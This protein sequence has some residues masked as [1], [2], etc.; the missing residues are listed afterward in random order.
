MVVQGCGPIG[1]MMIACLPT[2]GVN[3]IIALDGNDSRL[4]MAR[5]LGADHT[6]NYKLF[7]G[8]WTISPGQWRD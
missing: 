3:N 2:Y 6:L 7:A 8:G 5:R 1:L 4:E